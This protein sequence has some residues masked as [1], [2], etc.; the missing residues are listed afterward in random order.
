MRLVEKMRKE[1]Q[2]TILDVPPSKTEQKQKK[3]A[4]RNV[5][6]Y[7]V[8]PPINRRGEKSQSSVEKNATNELDDVREP[9]PPKAQTQILSVL[10]GTVMPTEYYSQFMDFDAYFYRR[11]GANTKEH[12]TSEFVEEEMKLTAGVLEDLLNDIVCDLEQ[13]RPWANSH[14]LTPIFYHMSSRPEGMV[15]ID[16][17]EDYIAPSVEKLAR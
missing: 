2:M 13:E 9:D 11:K 12:H 7:R 4:G 6:P 14:D 3:V 15:V 16:S 1:L 10:M 5:N 17:N 8:L